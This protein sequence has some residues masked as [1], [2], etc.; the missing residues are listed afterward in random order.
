[1][2][3]YVYIEFPALKSLGDKPWRGARGEAWDHQ[4]PVLF[5]VK[6]N[7]NCRNISLNSSSLLH[8][9]GSVT[10]VLTTPKMDVK[11]TL[12][13]AELSVTNTMHDSKH[14][15]VYNSSVLDRKD[16]LLRYVSSEIIFNQSHHGLKHR[17]KSAKSLLPY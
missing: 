11:V 7:W 10:D 1:M 17:Q 8:G 4:K 6:P 15:L 13:V 12:E 16:K 9:G 3:I 14:H 5:K 2:L